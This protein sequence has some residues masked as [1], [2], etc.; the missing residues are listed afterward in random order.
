MILMTIEANNTCSV[1]FF[2]GRLFFI[3]LWYLFLVFHSFLCWVAMRRFLVIEIWNFWCFQWICNLSYLHFYLHFCHKLQK[4][5]RLHEDEMKFG[6][7]EWS[8]WLKCSSTLEFWMPLSNC[9]WRS[10][11]FG[12]GGLKWKLKNAQNGSSK[13]FKMETQKR[14][15]WKHKNA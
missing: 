12:N 6:W 10:K 1:C 14:L 4:L 9:F 8:T 11:C 7:K 3:L 5:D 13:T 2:I 15:K